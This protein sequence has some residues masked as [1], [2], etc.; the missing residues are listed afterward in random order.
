MAEKIEITSAINLLSTVFDKRQSFIFPYR[1]VSRAEYELIPKAGR[2]DGSISTEKSEKSF[3]HVFKREAIPYLKRVPE[4]DWEYLFLAQHHGLST[5]LL[6][7]TKNPLVA[8]YFAVEKDY[9]ADCAIY[10]CKDR[11]NQININIHPDPFKMRDEVFLIYPTHITSRI[12]AQS[13]IFTIHSNPQK[14]YE[15]DNMVKFIIPSKY[16][17]II[18]SEL[19]VLGI[20]RASLFP[21]LDGISYYLNEGYLRD[22][23]LH[24]IVDSEKD[25]KT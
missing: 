1:G 22:V 10:T 6:D 4:N 11:I 9:D 20:H 18:K 23:R 13:G 17:S 25:S 24:E 12:V 8:L 19:L 3:L 16:R 21:D 14:A 7:W 5:R 15:P 2:F